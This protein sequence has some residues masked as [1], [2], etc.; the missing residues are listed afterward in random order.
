MLTVL[1]YDDKPPDCLGA[2][3][4]NNSVGKRKHST[5][6]KVINDP[7]ASEPPWSRIAPC[8]PD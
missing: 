5:A 2:D 8:S 6:G 4:S 7:I 1:R 3:G